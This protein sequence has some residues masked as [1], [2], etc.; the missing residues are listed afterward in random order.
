MSED[1]KK[2]K[3]DEEERSK[4]EQSLRKHWHDNSIC[5]V[6]LI[7]AEYDDSEDSNNDQTDESN[8]QAG[9]TIGH[10]EDAAH[11]ATTLAVQEDDENPHDDEPVVQADTGTPRV[12]EPFRRED[13]ENPHDDEPVVREDTGTPRVEEPFRREDDENPHEEESKEYF[14]IIDYDIDLDWSINNS[15]KSNLFESVIAKITIV[16]SIPHSTLNIEQKLVFMRLLGNALVAAIND[17][18]DEAER[19]LEEARNYVIQRLSE[20][21]KK[22][23]L[24]TATILLLFIIIIKW[25]LGKWFWN[26]IYPCWWNGVVWGISGAYLSIAYKAGK[27][28][29]DAEAGPILHFINVMVKFVCAALLGVVGILML[30]NGHIL[31]KVI[32]EIGMDNNGAQLIGFICGF[33]E[34]FI[35]SLLANLSKEK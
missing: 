6:E 32:N 11:L 25:I 8:H 34:K 9:D 21:S 27:E 18:C 31:P 33:S 3:L 17:Q 2:L 22:W 7:R 23:T 13:D 19:L 14:V 5:M 26:F 24:L 1:W 15:K 16:K 12:E 29:K 4:T 30:N 35:P 28:R 20:Y 10:T